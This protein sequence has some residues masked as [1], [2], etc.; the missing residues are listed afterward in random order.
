MLAWTEKKAA[1]KGD[2]PKRPPVL[3][4]RVNTVTTLVENK[5]AQLIVTAHDMDPIKLVIFL[6]ALCSKMGVPYCIIKRKARVGCLDHRK[7]C[8]TITLTQVNS[9]DK[10]LRLSWQ[11]LSR[12]IKMTDIMRSTVSGEAMSQN[13]SQ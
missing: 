4:T 2:V 3:P 12:P 6:L 11:K 10:E 8:T 7:T 13:Q 9:E 1:S 5:K